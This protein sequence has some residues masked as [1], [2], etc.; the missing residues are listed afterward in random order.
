MQAP[1]C[2]K[3]EKTPSAA[4]RT[5][6]P[7]RERLLSAAAVVFSRAGLVGATTRE[8]ARE[9]GV[10]EVTLFRH[11]QSKDGLIAA[12]VGKNFGPNVVHE[13]PV[14]PPT[15][16]D[17]RA[18]LLSFARSYEKILTENLPLVRTLIGEVHHEQHV[19][20]EKQVFKAIFLPLKEALFNRVE[21]AR[22]T[23]QIVGRMRADVLADLFFA[24]IF[25]GVLRRS[26]LHVKLEYSGTHYLESAIA[27]FLDGAEATQEKQS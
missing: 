22:K 9:A 7:A 24:M 18:D 15:T 17:L 10:N 14:V 26:A 13:N 23:G 27:L 16:S 19:L 12:V 20:H 8:I 25:T 5:R 4:R 11:F 21:A 2:M 6:P 3:Q 1:T